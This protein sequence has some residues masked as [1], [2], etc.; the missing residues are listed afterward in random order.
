MSEPDVQSF[1][2]IS[3]ELKQSLVD[4]EA[5]PEPELSFDAEPTPEAEAEIDWLEE[6][7]D[8]NIF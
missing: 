4:D 3:D 5:E 6:A 7:E 8:E 2:W 1:D